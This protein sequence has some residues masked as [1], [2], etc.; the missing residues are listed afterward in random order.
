MQH[1]HRLAVRVAARGLGLG[2]RLKYYQRDWCLAR[3][4]RHV[5]WTFDPLRAVNATL[6]IHRLGA[7]AN[8][9][10]PDYYGE[11]AGINSGLASDRLLVDWHLDSPV[12]AALALGQARGAQDARPLGLTLPEDL[13]QLAEADPPRAAELRQAL[14][15]QLQTAFAAGRRVVDF[16]R[17]RRE[18]LLEG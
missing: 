6:N 12:V 1:S 7:V 15:V 2:V 8:T 3:G 13:N 11:M 16:D 10:L 4:I 18:Y 5:R 17:V 9:Y 14:R